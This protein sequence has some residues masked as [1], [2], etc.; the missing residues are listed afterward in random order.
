MRNTTSERETAT[1]KALY[2]A[3]YDAAIFLRAQEIRDIVESAIYDNY[4]DYDAMFE[5]W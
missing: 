2:A 5:D 3:A 4:D 1:I